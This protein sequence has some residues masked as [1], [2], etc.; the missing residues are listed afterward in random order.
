[1]LPIQQLKPLEQIHLEW[2]RKRWE[3]TFLLTKPA[4]KEMSP[5]GTPS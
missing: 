4:E 1:M 5:T 3:I 2:P